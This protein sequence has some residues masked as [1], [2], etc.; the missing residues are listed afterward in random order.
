M[1]GRILICSIGD[2]GIARTL[3]KDMKRSGFGGATLLKSYS[4]TV[5]YAKEGPATAILLFPEL[6][7]DTALEANEFFSRNSIPWI[8]VE[9]S[10]RSIAIGP[11]VNPSVQGCYNCLSIRRGTGRKKGV[12][13]KKDPITAGVINGLCCEYLLRCGDDEKNKH[14]LEF[15]TDKEIGIDVHALIPDVDC[16]VCGSSK[17]VAQKIAPKSRAIKYSSQGYRYT[18]VVKSLN[19]MSPMVGKYGPIKEVG[20]AED[21][22]IGTTYDENRFCDIGFNVYYSRVRGGNVCIGKGP[23]YKQAMMSAVAEGIE[24][25][26][27]RRSISDKTVVSKYSDLTGRAVDPNEFLFFE[28][29]SPDYLNLMKRRMEWTQGYSITKNKMTW[30]PADL[31]YFPLRSEARKK[32][33]FLFEKTS[34]GLSAGN[35]IEEAVLQGVLELVERDASYLARISRR[36]YPSIDIDGMRDDHL[37]SLVRNIRAS[38]CELVLRDI[39]NDIGIPVVFALIVDRRRGEPA[40]SEGTGAH[41]DPAIAI[42]RAV[43]ESVQIKISQRLMMAGGHVVHEKDSIRRMIEN[44]VVVGTEPDLSRS[45]KSGK[46]L[47]ENFLAERDTS[48]MDRYGFRPTKDLKIAINWVIDRLRRHDVEIFVCNRSHR[49]MRLKVVRTLATGLQPASYVRVSQ[50]RIEA[51]KQHRFN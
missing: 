47:Y 39:T 11:R 6:K 24:R 22:L 1:I 38:G 13:Y 23:T 51:S 48:L 44:R 49:E 7:S 31:V 9:Y 10:E 5:I 33:K 45:F 27:G 3:L 17:P 43:T 19:R 8:P 21:L 16:A 46:L 12:G 26:C 30:L 32:K 4:K 15:S 20:N 2:Y 36:S 14:V 34:N 35:C 37:Y 40:F 25:L 42:T 41:I 29:D 50:K 18:D 28:K